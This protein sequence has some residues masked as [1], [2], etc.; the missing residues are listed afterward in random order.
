MPR[1]AGGR[2]SKY[3][4]RGLGRGR[5]IQIWLGEAHGK[6]EAWRKAG[7][8]RPACLAG[9]LPLRGARCTAANSL[10]PGIGT[11]PTAPRLAW[12]C[13]TAP[14]ALRLSRGALRGRRPTASSQAKIRSR[15]PRPQSGGTSLPHIAPPAYRPSAYRPSP[16]PSLPSAGS[17]SDRGV[18]V[19]LGGELRGLARAC[20][21]W[22][23][24][25]KQC[26]RVQWLP[27][28]AWQLSCRRRGVSRWPRASEHE[29]AQGGV[30]G[31]RVCMGVRV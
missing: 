1:Q 14:G 23:P 26:P 12:A 31:G 8:A 28:L 27:A 21:P 29:A 17:S 9:G 11:H 4:A 19:S 2:R 22:P 30:K 24:P 13:L 7:T 5:Q 25:Q 18:R 20:R 10:S 6:L 15:R 16:P 3:T